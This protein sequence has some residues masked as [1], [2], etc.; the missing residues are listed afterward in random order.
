M[1]R[2]A[3]FIARLV[4]LRDS[5]TA[6]HHSRVGAYA[7]AFADHLGLS[8][9]EAFQLTYGASIHDLGKL[10]V[11]EDILKKP[12]RLSEAEFAHIQQHCRLG[13][14]L[15]TPLRLDQSIEDI[16]LYHHENFDGSGYPLNL[17]QDE[18]PWLARIVRIIDSYDAM[19]GERPYRQPVSPKEALD[20]LNRDQ[21]FYDPDFLAQFEKFISK[22][23]SK[24]LFQDR[25][26]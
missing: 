8:D 25:L 2:I 7:S 12:R 10:A 26:Q 15:M 4:D 24:A 5:Y 13:L 3:G 20:I 9:K 11:D 18:I 22:Y 17:K 19:T 14:D 16:V 1:R 21:C 6:S 23:K